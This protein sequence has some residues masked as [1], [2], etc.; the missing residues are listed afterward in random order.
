MY[1][2]RLAAVSLLVEARTVAMAAD[3]SHPHPAQ[4]TLVGEPAHR[5]A[6]SAGAQAGTLTQDGTSPS[7]QQPAIKGCPISNKPRRK[8][9]RGPFTASPML[10]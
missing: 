2:T 10:R 5:Y 1:I 9:F 8:T 6:T 7:Q 4:H 3:A